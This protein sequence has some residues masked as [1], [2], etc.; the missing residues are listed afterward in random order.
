MEGEEERATKGIDIHDVA[1]DVVAHHDKRVLLD[2]RRR[3]EGKD[4]D[5]IAPTK[6]LKRNGGKLNTRVALNV[7]AFGCEKE[8]GR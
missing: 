4:R 8:L 2:V 6:F 7:E 5:D 3:F 1:L